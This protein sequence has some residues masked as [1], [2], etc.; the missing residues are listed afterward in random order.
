MLFATTSHG[1]PAYMCSKHHLKTLLTHTFAAGWCTGDSAEDPD[2][3]LHVVA[4]DSGTWPTDGGGVATCRELVLDYV[5]HVRWSVLSE[6]GNDF[7][8]VH[9]MVW[10]FDLPLDSVCAR[11]SVGG[12][13]VKPSRTRSMAYNQICTTAIDYRDDL[14][15]YYYSGQ[16]EALQSYVLM[17]LTCCKPACLECSAHPHCPRSLHQLAKTQCGMCRC[18]LDTLITRP[19]TQWTC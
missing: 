11:A 8:Q 7:K 10:V 5:Q 18:N 14:Q 9:L 2:G 12:T 6:I 3:S 17:L 1:I 4:V 16:S 13:K 19:W 15:G